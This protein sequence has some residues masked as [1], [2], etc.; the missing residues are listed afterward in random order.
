MK[1]HSKEEKYFLNDKIYLKIF[2]DP[3]MNKG[4]NHSKEEKQFL[5]DV[6]VRYRT[7]VFRSQKRSPMS[8]RKRIWV[9]LREQSVDNKLLCIPAADDVSLVGGC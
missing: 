5:N 4:E 7:G 3:M 8:M 1:N 2:P 9:G 6:G